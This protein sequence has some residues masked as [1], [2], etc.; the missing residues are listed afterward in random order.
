[1]PQTSRHHDQAL[2]TYLPILT[3]A[4]ST[5]T[6]IQPLIHTSTAFAPDE[7]D[8][9]FLTLSISMTYLFLATELETII[10]LTKDVLS[11]VPEAPPPYVKNRRDLRRTVEAEEKTKGRQIFIHCERALRKAGE[12]ER[13]LGGL[14]RMAMEVP[15]DEDGYGGRGEGDVRLLE[16]CVRAGFVTEECR[17]VV[18]Q[19]RNAESRDSHGRDRAV[20][21]VW[22]WRCRL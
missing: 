22:V 3:T 6:N 8:L 7:E 12:G 15:E 20:N 1:M 5:I 16:S 2:D 14:Q 9:A 11:E 18:V 4:Q 17:E 19:A 10:A 13:L 21:D